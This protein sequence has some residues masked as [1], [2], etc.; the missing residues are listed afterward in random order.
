LDDARIYNRALSAS[1][2][3]QLYDLESGPRVIF[4]KAF[5]VDFSGLMVG[6]NYQLQASADLN[7]WTNFGAAFTATSIDY[8]NT[9]YQRIDDWNK[10]FFR[11]QLAP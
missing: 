8:T 10:L 2:I 4:V 6:S 11:L 1:E 7:T 5:T 9:G 3:Q